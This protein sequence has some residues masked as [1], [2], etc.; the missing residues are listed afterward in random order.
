MILELKKN[1][2]LFECCRLVKGD[3]R[4]LLADFQRRKLEFLDN[5][6]SEILENKSRE[7]SV[8]EILKHYTTENQEI[9]LEYFEFLIEN[10]YA[11]QCSK[12]EINLFPKMDLTW[13]NPAEITNCIIDLEDYPVMV[14]AYRK[15]ISDL[16]ILG[17]E[18]LQI[19]NF[20]GISI[21]NI[22]SFLQL[23]NGTIITRIEILTLKNYDINEYV[24]LMNMFVRVSVLILHS[25]EADSESVV[26]SSQKILTTKQTI[27]SANYCGLVNPNYFNLRQEHYLESLNFNTCLN[28]KIG[29]DKLGNIKNCPSMK[30]VYGNIQD[31]SILD[32]VK[33]PEFRKLWHV[34][35]NDIKVCKDCEF[36]HLCTDCRAF[37]E[38]D[39]SIEKPY[40]CTYN[41][42]EMI[43]E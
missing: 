41:P 2:L 38:S 36:R 21:E 27:S 5:E 40:K 29:I 20:K 12:E 24:I 34:K 15:I 10:E 17:C 31:T 11:F 35:K 28:R 39:E 18:N 30:A 19:R 16:E 14:D 13:D 33:Q 1:I 3:G 37:L 25:A 26:S 4:T 23:F 43:C 42:Y 8:Q 22:S 9:I 7:Y 6:I 32:V